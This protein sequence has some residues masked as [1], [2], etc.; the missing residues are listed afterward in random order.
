ME[1]RKMSTDS[2]SPTKTSAWREIRTLAAVLCGAVGAAFALAAFLLTQYGPSGSIRLDAALIS[3]TV[4][5]DLRYANHGRTLV[6]DHIELMDMKGNLRGVT[7][8]QYRQIYEVIAK[9]QSFLP[10]ESFRYS[11]AFTG[12][13]SSIAIKLRPATQKGSGL[14]ILQTLV[15]ASSGVKGM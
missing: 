11:G 10:E 1:K 12:P 3:P 4:L 7:L 9:D 2:T 13:S 8:D 6:F 15:L 14:E 5:E